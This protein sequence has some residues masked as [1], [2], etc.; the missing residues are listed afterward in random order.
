MKKTEVTCGYREEFENGEIRYHGDSTDNGFCYKNVAAFDKGEG[1]IYIGEY[2]LQDLEQRK[3]ALLWTKDMII[4][5]V[6]ETLDRAYPDEMANNKK[7]VTWLARYIL[8]IC[9]WQELSTYLMELTYD[10]SIE[11]MYADRKLWDK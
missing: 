4:N 1:V 5:E 10:E 2:S 9:D 3:D 7:F 11:E 8:E 6:Q